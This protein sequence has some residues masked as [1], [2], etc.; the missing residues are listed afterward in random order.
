MGWVGYLPC[1]DNSGLS[2]KV[3]LNSLGEVICFLCGTTATTILYSLIE[4]TD[5][6]V[7]T[8]LK[9]G[10]LSNDLGGFCCLLAQAGE[11]IDIVAMLV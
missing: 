3:K 4:E 9:D 10:L 8:I 1:G 2:L 5:K 6:G 11:D 7:A